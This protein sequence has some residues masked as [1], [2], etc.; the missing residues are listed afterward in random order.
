MPVRTSE[1]PESGSLMRR[2]SYR[3][4]QGSIL[5][6]FAAFLIL[7]LTVAAQDRPPKE[8][9]KREAHLIE[10]ITLEPTIKLDIRYA[11]ENNFVGRK[12]YREA[13]AFLQKPAAKGVA[14]V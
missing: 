7:S 5:A 9:G 10:L 4:S 8:S 11:T 12:V 3:A 6:V 13:R 2:L 14:R 1:Y